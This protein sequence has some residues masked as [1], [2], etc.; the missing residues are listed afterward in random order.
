[1]LIYAS[2]PREREAAE[3]KL[4][5]KRKKFLTNE[6]ICDK[7]N[8]LRDEEPTAR[9][10]AKSTKEFEKTCKKCLTN[11]TRCANISKFAA[12]PIGAAKCEK[13]YLVN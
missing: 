13:L 11:S 9:S 7:I 3:K 12:A 1:M 5:K 8:Q 6:S 10:A 2:C 4:E